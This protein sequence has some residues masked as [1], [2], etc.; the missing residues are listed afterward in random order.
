MITTDPERRAHTQARVLQMLGQ[1]SSPDERDL[2]LAFARLDLEETPDAIALRLSPESLAARIE[3]HFRFV[4][5]SMP[6]PVQA[7]RGLPGIHVSVRQPD[8]DEAAATGVGEGLPMEY[9]LVETHTR[10]VP[11]IFDSLKNYFAK[12]GLRVFGAVHPIF[13]VRRQWERVVRFGGPHDEGS[14]EVY[15][16]FQVEPLDS[17]ERL[18]RMEHEI[19]SVLK[20]VFLAVEDFPDMLERTRSL[21]GRL[22]SHPSRPGDEESA[23]AFLQWLADENYIFMG[24]AHYAAGPGGRLEQSGDNVSGVFSDPELLPVVFPG[25]M[26]NVGAH[27]SPLAGD[28]RIINIDYCNNAAAIYHLEPIDGVVIR[29]WD[30]E[31]GLKGCT[32]LLGRFARSAL[33]QRAD[34][35]PILREKVQWII[36]SSGVPNN[37]HIYREMITT[38][39]RLPMCELFYAAPDSLKAMIEPIVYMLRD[40]EIS[41]HRRSGGCYEAVSVAYSRLRYSYETERNLRQ[42]LAEAFGPISFHTSADCGAASVLLCYFDTAQLTRPP[43]PETV[44]AIAGPLLATWES[45]VSSALEAAFGER[46]GRRFFERYVRRE[47]RSGLYREVTAPEEVPD[48]V[49]HFEALTGRLEVHHRSPRRAPGRARRRP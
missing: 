19:F 12:A 5:H 36:D 37:S 46:E 32:L 18:R 7:Y 4:V 25:F 26:D 13:T 31:G 9:T 47:S 33:L 1:R 29:E 48:D 2:L 10:D 42:A 21:A 45:R 44:R 43:D 14:R 28:R 38:F 11:F 30:A 8:E 49:R 41:V 24:V 3:G 35:I 15:C 20:C 22:C 17:R 23:R 40:D 6:P 34:R 16:N 39:N 27:I